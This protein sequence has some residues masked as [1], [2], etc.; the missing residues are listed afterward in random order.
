MALERL[1]PGDVGVVVR[2]ALGDALE[3]RLRCFGL[4]P[5]TRVQCRYLSPDGSLTALELRGTVIAL[6]TRDLKGIRVVR[7]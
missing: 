1:M 6:R 7:E 2:M 4:V 5:G 3:G